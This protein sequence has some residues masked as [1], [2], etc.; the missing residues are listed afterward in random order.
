MPSTPVCASDASQVNTVKWFTQALESRL[1][2][3]KYC[4][5]THPNGHLG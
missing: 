2:G 4:S 3:F 1:S 5:G